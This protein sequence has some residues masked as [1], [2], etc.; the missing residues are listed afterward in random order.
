MKKPNIF[1]RLFGFAKNW[2]DKAFKIFEHEGAAGVIATNWLK[3]NY[4]NGNIE[5]VAN[6][7]PGEEDDILVAKAKQNVLPVLEAYAYAH[8]LAVQGEPRHK[9]V[10]VVFD[11]ISTLKTRRSFWAEISSDLIVMLAD[12]KID[13]NEGLILGQK[14]FWQLF[15]KNRKLG[16]AA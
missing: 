13:W 7:I 10:K 5:A 14:L 6:F 8:N 3:E 4:E 16:L 12:G 11:H 15:N 1:A 9:V 2:Y